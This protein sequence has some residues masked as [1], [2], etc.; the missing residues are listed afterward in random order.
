MNNIADDLCQAY[1]DG[2]NDALKERNK[3]GRW[4]W[5]LA[6]NGWANHICSNCGYTKNTDVHVKLD[7]RFCPYC[8]SYNG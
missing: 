7:W 1:T 8:G 2:Y 3:T 5:E 4:L 6:D